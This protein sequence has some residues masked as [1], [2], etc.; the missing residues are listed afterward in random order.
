MGRQSLEEN[1]GMD[2]FTSC[3]KES[4]DIREKK[5]ANEAI[6]KLDSCT[7]EYKGV[8]Y[9]ADPGLPTFQA[10]IFEQGRGQEKYDM[11][12]KAMSVDKYI[13]SQVG[14]FRQRDLKDFTPREAYE[15][16]LNEDK[17]EG[18]KESIREGETIP[19]PIVSYDREGELEMFQ[20][21]RHRGEAVKELGKDRI[22]V[23]VAERCGRRGCGDKDIVEIHG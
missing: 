2:R 11:T 5:G 10:N 15:Y 23:W 6:E 14:R 13:D 12:V 21:G 9:S 22:L 16:G 3:I 4:G 8:K 1:G 18:M 19:M 17:V 7:L 20:E